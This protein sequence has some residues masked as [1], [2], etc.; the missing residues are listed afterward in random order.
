MGRKFE[1]WSRSQS[2]KFIRQVKEINEFYHRKYLT[3]SP[4]GDYYTFP[5]IDDEGCVEDGDKTSKYFGFLQEPPKYLS[6]EESTY[7][8][9]YGP[10]TNFPSNHPNLNENPISTAMLWNRAR[11]MVSTT[12]FDYDG[13]R[14]GTNTALTFLKES[15]PCHSMPEKKETT[16]RTSAY[17]EPMEIL[18]TVGPAPVVKRCRNVARWETTY[19]RDFSYD[20]IRK[21][22]FPFPLQ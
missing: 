5:A 1:Y 22:V 10:K 14:I 18:T 12:Q 7:S 2:S 9:H 4:L 3:K 17:S 6:H 15:C 19:G 16:K 20:P 11:D 21:P 8:D 13:R